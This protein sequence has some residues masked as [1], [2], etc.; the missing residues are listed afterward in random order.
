MSDVVTFLIWHGEAFIFVYVFAD[1]V[2]VPVPAVPALLAIYIVV[3]WGQRRR[4]LRSLRIARVSQEELKR[5]VIVYVRP[6]EGGF[7]AW[8]ERGFPV[9][10]ISPPIVGVT[11]SS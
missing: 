4:F 3:K 2:G 6:L 1:Q 5:D 8:R 10:P 9:E 11:G 7:P